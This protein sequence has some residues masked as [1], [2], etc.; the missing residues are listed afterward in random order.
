MYSDSSDDGSYASTWDTQP[1]GIPEKFRDIR[2]RIDQLYRSTDDHEAAF[3]ALRDEY[4]AL[5]EARRAINAKA[6]TL[7]RGIARQHE[8]ENY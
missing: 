4:R 5:F 3:R 7:L 8:A 1:K 2:A 6:N